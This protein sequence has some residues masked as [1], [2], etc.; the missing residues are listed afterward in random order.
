MSVD[1]SERPSVN[2]DASEERIAEVVD[3]AELRAR[4]FRE[5]A[6]QA[7]C[8]RD[9]ISDDFWSIGTDIY[10]ERIKQKLRQNGVNPET[11]T[12]EYTKE[13]LKGNI[14]I[15]ELW[16]IPDTGEIHRAKIAYAFPNGIACIEEYDSE[17]NKIKIITKRDNITTTQD[18]DS[19][20]A[21]RIAVETTYPPFGSRKEVVYSYP[22]PVSKPT[23][24]PKP[25]QIQTIIYSVHNRKIFETV[26]RNGS[27]KINYK[28]QWTYDENGDVLEGREEE[29]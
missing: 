21:L 20:G 27:G 4:R 1:D 22:P 23:N 8:A 25:I 15:V 28:G 12:K 6:G 24:L 5:L 26:D 7:V 10:I 13:Y 16:N 3:L 11:L 29:F 9:E 19:F 17:G 2:P 18:Y 14:Q